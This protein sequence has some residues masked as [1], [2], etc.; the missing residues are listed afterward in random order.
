MGGGDWISTPVHWCLLGQSNL[1]VRIHFSSLFF[2]IS[3]VR[4]GWPAIWLRIVGTVE[5]TMCLMVLD[6]SSR[7]AAFPYFTAGWQVSRWRVGWGAWEAREL[8]AREWMMLVAW[9]LS[10]LYET[11]QRHGSYQWWNG[12]LYPLISCSGLRDSEAWEDGWTNWGN[13]FG[14]LMDQNAPLWLDRDMGIFL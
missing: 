4:S 5:A 14:D 3:A 2:R 11:L 9:A 1:K 10:S 12:E 13:N 6:D 7:I 8:A